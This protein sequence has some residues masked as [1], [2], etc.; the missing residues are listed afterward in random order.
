MLT[1]V[2]SYQVLYLVVLL[3]HSTVGVR[4]EETTRVTSSTDYKETEITTP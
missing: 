4:K 1:S 3:T 2:Y